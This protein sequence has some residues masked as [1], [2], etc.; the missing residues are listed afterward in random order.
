[1]VPPS[2]RSAIENHLRD[3][4]AAARILIRCIR[5]RATDDGPEGEHVGRRDQQVNEAA[6]V[7]GELREARSDVE[8]HGGAVIKYAEA[9]GFDANCVRALLAGQAIDLEGLDGFIHDV[10]EHVWST[11][12]YRFETLLRHA[13][14]AVDLLRGMAGA[15]RPP[16]A[17]HG[18]D[19]AR[20]EKEAEGAF[21]RLGRSMRTARQSEVLGN[22]KH[23][24][25]WQYLEELCRQLAGAIGPSDGW[26][27]VWMRVER[28]L[29]QSE[30]PD[31]ER[32]E[33]EF[34][35][36]FLRLR[37]ERDDPAWRNHWPAIGPGD[38][39]Q[40]KGVLLRARRAMVDAVGRLRGYAELSS[41]T[42]LY[43]PVDVLITCWVDVLPH[44]R[45]WRRDVSIPQA[46]VQ[47]VR[48]SNGVTVGG[49]TANTAGQVLL[50][51]CRRLHGWLSA[52]PSFRPISCYL[53]NECADR[54][55]V[56]LSTWG[57]VACDFARRALPAG[58]APLTIGSPSWTDSHQAILNAL[59]NPKRL[60]SLAA[61]VR[62]IPVAEIE[63][64][65]R[66]LGGQVAAIGLDELERQVEWEINH[67]LLRAGAFK[68]A[69]SRADS[70]AVT[71]MT[72]PA[73]GHPS[74]RAGLLG[75]PLGEAVGG[76]RVGRDARPANPAPNEL[77]A[78]LLRAVQQTDRLGEAIFRSFPVQGRPWLLE[79]VPDGTAAV[80]DVCGALTSVDHALRALRDWQDGRFRPDA[81]WPGDRLVPNGIRVA[82]LGLLTSFRHIVR[83]YGWE[84][85]PSGLAPE[86][87]RPG[88]GGFG[89]RWPDV[90]P[91]PGDR[92]DAL[93]SAAVALKTEVRAWLSA[94]GA[95]LQPFGRAG[96]ESA[97]HAPA[98]SQ[99]PPARSVNAPHAP[100]AARRRKKERLHEQIAK[101]IR[102][103][104]R[105]AQQIWDC[106]HAFDATLVHNGRTKINAKYMLIRFKKD[107]KYAA[108]VN[109]L[110]SI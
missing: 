50:E 46:F 85:P 69:G 79:G 67:A 9:N 44:D 25:A 19:S 48:D 91:L 103:G 73:E 62:K 33:R 14:L 45:T 28:V 57:D 5:Q 17:A 95:T 105:S 109:L 47:G 13:F 98:G 93:T 101:A 12:D 53:Y 1:M 78:L 71:G 65:A 23:L 21:E 102:E 38:A 30:A 20:R 107:A 4:R 104:K 76:V 100:G 42:F 32:F 16:G 60:S 35:D 99:S 83:Q 31:M 49:V 92:L 89:W 6:D 29:R 41:R 11:P 110:Q 10:Y 52:S 68:D 97:D 59:E 108:E 51:Q 86:L 40:L 90:P 22:W 80:E 96:S 70:A 34:R 82:F 77:G 66:R 58:L 106:V 81:P 2:E 15:D 56:D 18:L 88:R 7:G 43:P 94:A 84:P 24:L 64:L 87:D 37:G 54:L 8:R 39:G 74:L 36:N 26:P 3:L 61:T 75:V 55:A 27:T 72:A 63:D